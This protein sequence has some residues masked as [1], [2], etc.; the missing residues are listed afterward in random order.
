MSSLLQSLSQTVSSAFASAGYDPKLGTVTASDRPDLC[1]F[2]CNGALQ[3]AKEHREKPRDV[4]LKVIG[5]LRE[6]P[7]SAAIFAK[8]DV[9]GP[10]FINIDAADDWI[11]GHIARQA[12]DERLGVDRVAAPKKIFIDYGGANIAKPMHVG[13]LRSSIIGDSLKRIAR[14]LG[15]EVVG[16]IHLGDWGLQMGMLIAEMARRQPELSYFAAEATGDFPAESPVTISDLQQLYPEASA[17]AKRDTEAMAA[18]RAATAELQSGRAGYRALWRHFVAVSVAEL[19]ADLADLGVDFDLWL[20]ESDVTDQIPGLIERLESQG[21]ARLHEGALIVDV[22]EADDKRE[23]PP[24]LLAKSDG[25]AL[26]ATTDLA[27]LEQRVRQGARSMLYVVDNR[28]ADHF[29]QV[30]RAARK[31]GLAAP[32]IELEHVGFGTMNGPDGKPFKTRE[33]GVMRLKDLMSSVTAKARERMAE[34]KVAADYSAEEKDAIA[35]DV[36]LAALKYADLVNHR[37]KDY[38][39]DL[40]R[41][42]SFEGKTGPYLLYAVVR[43]KSILDNAEARGL[44]AGALMAPASDAERALLLSLAAFPDVVNQAFDA[45]APSYLAEYAH[46]L[47]TSFNKFYAEHHILSEGDAA[48]QASWLALV[49]DTARVLEKALE[50]LGIHV[51]RRM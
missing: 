49:S 18:A 43:V 37:A 17:R 35:A 38:V 27:T 7:G 5:A 20:G 47:A 9:A 50:M 21:A 8:L 46:S 34:A 28:Q 10:G 1:Q 31:T 40:E 44:K 15:H 22:A 12:A 41:F 24:L 32:D 39:F 16:D 45:R 23:L 19:R 13:H 4:A 51:P 48:R 14:F 11:V 2:Q 30:F 3:A 29:L 42:S 6:A 33:G 36:G 25:A 26:Y